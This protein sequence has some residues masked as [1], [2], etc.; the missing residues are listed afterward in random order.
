MF[1]TGTRLRVIAT[2]LNRKLQNC[3]G[4]TSQMVLLLIL[5]SEPLVHLEKFMNRESTS[6]CSCVL[7][8]Y[9]NSLSLN[10]ILISG[11]DGEHQTPKVIHHE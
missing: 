11:S 1:N 2:R 8:K 3:A 7:Q 10:W 9:R 4:T 6:D 5:L